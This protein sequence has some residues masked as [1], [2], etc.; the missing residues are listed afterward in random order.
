MVNHLAMKHGK[1][2]DGHGQYFLETICMIWKN[3]LFQSN[4]NQKPVMTGLWFATFL[5]VYVH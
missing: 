1:L 5:K 4:I 2:R 3:G